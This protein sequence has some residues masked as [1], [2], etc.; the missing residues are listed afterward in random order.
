MTIFDWVP[1]ACTLPTTD[2]PLRLAEFDNLFTTALRGVTRTSPTTLELILDA[3]AEPTA[4]DLTTR[5]TACCS[6]FTFTYTPTADGRLRLKI[7]VPPAHT[8][9]LDALEARA[10]TF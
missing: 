2:Q 6:F 5:E 3:A 4:T 10:S 7:T 8:A 9:V 1:D